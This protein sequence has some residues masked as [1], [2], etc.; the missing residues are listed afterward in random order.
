MSTYP[1]QKDESTIA[2]LSNLWGEVV[3][4]VLEVQSAEVDNRG[5]CERLGEPE[6][7]VLV[8]EEWLEKLEVTLEDSYYTKLPNQMESEPASEFVNMP[9]QMG[10]KAVLTPARL[11]PLRKD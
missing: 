5:K 1:I 8:H 4:L 6:V 10:Y 9:S 11:I 7:T 3:S 2:E